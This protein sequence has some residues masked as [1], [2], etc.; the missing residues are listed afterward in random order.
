MSISCVKHYFKCLTD[1]K[2]TINTEFDR[3]VKS[4]G[5][6]NWYPLKMNE[7]SLMCIKIISESDL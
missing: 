4:T 7:S 5:N 1:C 2:F 3:T 6:E